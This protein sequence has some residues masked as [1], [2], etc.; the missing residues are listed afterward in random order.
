M[1]IRL[2]RGSKIKSLD[3]KKNNKPTLLTRTLGLLDEEVKDID[4]N[5]L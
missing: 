2:G 3:N 5:R 4:F 1:W